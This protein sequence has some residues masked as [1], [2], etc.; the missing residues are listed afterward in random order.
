VPYTR[1][2]AGETLS[3]AK[4]NAVDELETYAAEHVVWIDHPDDL[5]RGTATFDDRNS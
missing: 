2:P 1:F 4:P 5:V 3:V